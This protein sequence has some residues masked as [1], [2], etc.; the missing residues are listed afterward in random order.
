MMTNRKAENV[1]AMTVKI[2]M[3]LANEMSVQ[4]V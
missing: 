4:V 2:W 1:D 3:Q